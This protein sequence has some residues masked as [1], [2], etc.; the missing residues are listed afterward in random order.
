MSA[1]RNNWM[2]RIQLLRSRVNYFMARNANWNYIKPVCLIVAMV[3]MILLGW[4][5][6]VNTIQGGCSWKFAVP[7]GVIHS[8]TSLSFF[9]VLQFLILFIRDEFISV[10]LT[11]C[12]VVCRF[13]RPLFI[14]LL[15]IFA[16]RW[17]C[18]ISISKIISGAFFARLTISTPFISV[19][20][21]LIQRLGL[22]A[23]GASFLHRIKHGETPLN[24]SPCYNRNSLCYG[25]IMARVR[26]ECVLKHVLGSL[27]F[28]DILHPNR[29][30]IK[31]LGAY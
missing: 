28:L 22:T 1:P 24:C 13:Q 9:R 2:N 23:F 20:A 15:N 4:F 17:I 25:H 7:N 14:T 19:T 6:T 5:S 30:S 11:P 12:F 3:M 26:A 27:L 10:C 21:K 8:I 18:F 31:M 29:C 16:Q